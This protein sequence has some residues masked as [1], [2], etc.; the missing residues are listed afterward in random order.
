MTDYSA[1]AKYLLQLPYTRRLRPDE[2]GGYVASILE[3]P[4]CVADGESA[5]EALHNLDETA[6]AWL[7]VAIAN[8]QEIR[9]P[10]DLGGASG[11][12]ALRI[13]RSLH[14]QVAEM[15]QMEGTSVNQLLVA[16]IA[17]YVGGK[18]LFRSLS[19]GIASAFHNT[20]APERQRLRLYQFENIKI[21]HGD[22][23]VERDNLTLELLKTSETPLVIERM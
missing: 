2:E 22:Y 4:G 3:F 11:K 21:V 20:I 16:A 9:E 12:I 23:Q 19:Q 6:E 13:P 14:K 7:E 10:I 1:K 8:G 15:A 18:E 5:E 17:H